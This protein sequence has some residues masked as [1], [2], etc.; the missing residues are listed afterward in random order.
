MSRTQTMVQLNRELLD[1][2]DRAAERRGASRSAL[3]RELLWAGLAE[4][5]EA[6]IGERIVEGYRRLPAAEPDA[7]GDLGAATEASTEEVMAR[8]DAEE[9][10]AGY[11]PW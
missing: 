11:G 7:W 10:E 1:V 4:D 2:L 9:R 8:L 6:G 3:I 5:R